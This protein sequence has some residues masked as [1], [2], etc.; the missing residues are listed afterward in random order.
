MKKNYLITG[1]A[2]FIGYHVSKFLLGKKHNVIC[3]DNIN[4]YYSQ[5]LK[6][7]RIKNLS[8]NKNFKFFK[9]DICKKKDLDRKLSNF[10]IHKIVH[11]AAQAGVRNA[12]DYPR[13]YFQSNLL[14]FFN[15]IEF[16]RGRKIKELLCASTSS[17]YGDQKISFK[18]KI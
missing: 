18:R 8:K 10:K 4:N 12:Y 7:D 14:G 2:G 1:G 16:A 3:I 5:K 6:K 9:I 13:T 17:I 11:L 15:I